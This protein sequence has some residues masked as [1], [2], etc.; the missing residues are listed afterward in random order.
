MPEVVRK[1]IG[2]HRGCCLLIAALSLV[3]ACSSPG[4]KQATGASDHPTVAVGSAPFRARPGSTQSPTSGEPSAHLTKTRSTA[5]AIRVGTGADV[6]DVRIPGDGLTYLIRAKCSNI[7]FP[8][9]L[10]QAYGVHECWTGLYGPADN[11][12]AILYLLGSKPGSHGKQQ[13]M[14]ADRVNVVSHLVDL[15]PGLGEAHIEHLGRFCAV[16]NYE[17][18]QARTYYELFKDRVVASCKW[19]T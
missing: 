2:L 18:S 9:Q 17:S 15:R 7:P 8:G 5:S 14:V 4:T 1:M 12:S 3:A 6:G 13:I 10:A 19:S 11:T 16:I